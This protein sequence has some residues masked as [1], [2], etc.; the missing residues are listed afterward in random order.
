MNRCLTR[1]Q[2]QLLLA[3][4][5]DTA[6]RRAIDSHV[7]TCPACQEKLACLLDEQAGDYPELNYE[8]LRP[9][10]PE[11][12]GPSVAD[13]LRRLKD[14]L[15]P[16]ATAAGPQGEAGPSDIRFP[17]PPTEYGPL[18]QLES[19]HVMAE[20]GRGAFGIVFQAYDEQ[21]RSTVALKVLK[22]ELT[23]SPTDRARFQSKARKA[24]A[25]R[26]DHVVTIHRLGN[27]PGFALP[28][29]VMEYIDGE[30][31]SDRLRRQGASRDVRSGEGWRRQVGQGLAAAHRR[32]L[33]HRDINPA[34]ILLERETGRAKITDFGLA[35]SLKLRHRAAHANGRHHGHTAL[36]EPGADHGRRADRSPQRRL[37]SWRGV[38]RTTYGRASVPWPTALNPA[39]GGTRRAAATRQ[40][41]R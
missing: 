2:F 22:P 40:A 23:A 38:V 26:H 25:V 13:F 32:G 24:A 21:L 6:Q 9:A 8:R 17:G 29:F 31:L 37:Q 15:A 28:Y 27:T 30:S 11:D 41:E 5:L 39:P 4:Q 7:D 10:R 20:R 12:D 14:R 16:V 1:E 33:V 34:N 35:R 19:Y 18:G 3:E 36:H